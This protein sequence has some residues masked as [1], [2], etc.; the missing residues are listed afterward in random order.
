LPEAP[1]GDGWQLILDTRE[2]QLSPEP[3]LLE[4][5]QSFEMEARSLALFILPRKKEAVKGNSG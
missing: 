3:R 1:E 5:G 2:E 4:G